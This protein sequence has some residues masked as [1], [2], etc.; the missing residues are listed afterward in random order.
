MC[1]SDLLL[2]P[3]DV[4]TASR[5]GSDLLLASLGRT[6]YLARLRDKGIV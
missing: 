1:S 5:S 2:A 4:L 6:S 3:G